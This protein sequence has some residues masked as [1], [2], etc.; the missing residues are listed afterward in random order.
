[1]GEMALLQK[2]PFSIKHFKK[3]PRWLCREGP[4]PAAAANKFR[5]ALPVRGRAL[6]C[7]PI[8]YGAVT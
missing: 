3:R 8:T 6:L 2:G 5:L 4:P 7:R 1:M